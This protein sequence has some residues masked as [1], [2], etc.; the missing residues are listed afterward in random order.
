MEFVYQNIYISNSQTD[1]KKTISNLYKIFWDEIKKEFFLWIEPEKNR[2]Y[3]YGLL[4]EGA[5]LSAEANPFV[6]KRETIKKYHPILR[7]NLKFKKISFTEPKKVSQYIRGYVKEK[8]DLGNEILRDYGGYENHIRYQARSIIDL[9]MFWGMNYELSVDDYFPL[10][11][12][13]ELFDAAKQAMSYTSVDKKLLDQI[14]PLLLAPILNLPIVAIDIEVIPRGNVMPNARLAPEPISSIAFAFSE[15]QAFLQGHKNVVI[16]LGSYIRQI[17]LGFKPE[18]M[19]MIRKGEIKIEWFDD[20]I[21]LIQ[22]YIYIIYHAKVA[23]VAT[24]NGDDFDL[25]YLQSRMEILGI[26]NDYLVSKGDKHK[27]DKYRMEFRPIIEDIHHYKIHVDEYKF[28]KQP[29][30]KNYA[31]S[32]KYKYNKLDTISSALLNESKV[33]Y[34][35]SLSDLELFP[36]V[37]YN[38]IDAI[39]TLKLMLFDDRITLSLMIYL[40]RLGFETLGEVHR[41]AITDKIGNLLIWRLYHKNW[42]L[43][44]KQDMPKSEATIKSKGGNKDFAGADVVEPIPGIHWNVEVHD[45]TGL[46]TNIIDKDNLSPET[47]NCPHP[48]CQYNKVPGMEHHVCK[49]EKGI[50]SEIVGLI[51]GIRGNFFKKLAKGDKKNGIPPNPLFTP[52]EQTLKTFGNASYGAVSAEFFILYSVPFA[53]STTGIGRY[54]LAGIIEKAISLGMEV[55]YGDT[56]SAFLKNCTP[57]KIKE[58]YAYSTNE[59]GLNLDLEKSARFVILTPRKKNYLF[60]YKDGTYDLKGLKGKKTS[61]PQII[62]D[63]LDDVCYRLSKMETPDQY[64]KTIFDISEIIKKYVRHIRKKKGDI[65]EYI[66]Y[67]KLNKP[68]S[69]YKANTQHLKA[70]IL[71]AEHIRSN[72]PKVTAESLTNDDIIPLGHI[73]GYIKASHHPSESNVL[74][75]ILAENKYLNVNAY[76]KELTSTLS[77]MTDSL[78]I[79]LESLMK[80]E[81]QRSLTGYF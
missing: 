39:L 81:N 47:M 40:M 48:E 28:F 41:Y 7:K 13:S 8:D 24:F 72:L 65:E 11:Y 64:D 55:V 78:N 19:E 52:V 3:P 38:M 14:L 37:Y 18:L 62:K 68:I 74:P 77:Q 45:F 59:L 4:K 9:D 6:V 15:P 76:L 5:K 2:H 35:G 23:I 42:V 30:I 20:E 54:S 61:T 25:R 57:E 71:R 1:F 32:G 79:N 58:L 66:Y 33:N 51:T 29:V 69:M 75:F 26:K 16:A 80:N 21:S 70:A 31:F 17:P 67:A 22:R 34:E 36:L 63:C 44:R 60:M 43:W 12:K 10:A 49:L 27:P 53:E 73:Q 46:Y 50:V 56:D